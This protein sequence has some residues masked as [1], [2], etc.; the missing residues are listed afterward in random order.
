MLLSIIMFILAISIIVVN[1]YFCATAFR[2]K[3]YV[4]ATLH[5][6]AAFW[7]LYEISK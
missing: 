2:Q 3:K 1:A 4:W 5:A 7:M 6:V